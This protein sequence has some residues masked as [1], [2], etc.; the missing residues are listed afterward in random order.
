MVLQMTTMESP[1]ARAK[2]FTEADFLQL[3][4][5]TANHPKWR[6]Y[7]D[8]CNIKR[9]KKAY[10]MTPVTCADV[11]ATFRDL[12]PDHPSRIGKRADPVHLLI[13]LRWLWKYETE[14]D[15]GRFFSLTE[16]TVTKWI[17]IYVK[18]MADYQPTMMGTLESNDKGFMFLM[19][20]DGTH[21]PIWEPKPWSKANSSYKYGG[22]PGVN[23]ELG[24]SLYEPKLMWI[25]GPTQPG[26]K[27][28]LMVFQEKLKGELPPDK[29]VIA[30]GIFAPEKEHCSTKNDLDP[31]PLAQLKYRAC[32]RHESFN[33]RLKC[34][35]CLHKMPYRHGRTL[36]NAPH[37]PH[38]V[39]FRA[40]CL[41][42]QVQLDNGST[43]LFDA[44]DIE[45]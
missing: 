28:D 32:A 15:L 6:Q 38:S 16:K 12:P 33:Q 23:Y 4:L 39:A 36:K 3:G 41:L 20:I 25:H 34:F 10:G 21:C 24:I 42:V 11:W 17:R 45:R 29:R 9:F 31:K 37:L 44:W 7:K 40:C 8:H 27:T 18:K 43:H 35:N 26:A 1:P 22:S 5:E 30:D 13:A 2:A 14:A 19:S